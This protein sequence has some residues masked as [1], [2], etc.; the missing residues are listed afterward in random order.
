MQHDSIDG[1]RELSISY[2]SNF[3]GGVAVSTYQIYAEYVE[4]ICA[5]KTLE[6]LIALSD[7]VE[8]LY[9]GF[10]EF[11]F[12]ERFGEQWSRLGSPT[13]VS[14]KRLELYPIRGLLISTQ[15][16]TSAIQAGD[17]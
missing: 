5:T 14:A 15:C 17:V 11:E 16:A 1:V 10:R 7:E 8:R 12:G 2:P 6:E 3:T 4:K 13:R 9:P